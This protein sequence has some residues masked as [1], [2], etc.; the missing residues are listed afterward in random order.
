MDDRITVKEAIPGYKPGPIESL[1]TARIATIRAGTCGGAEP[2][3]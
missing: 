2:P 3:S 1:D